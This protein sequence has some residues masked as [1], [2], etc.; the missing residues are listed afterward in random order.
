M[1][2]Y[3]NWFAYVIKLHRN[4]VYFLLSFRSLLLSLPV[5][6]LVHI[7]SYISI[8]EL[9]TSVTRTCK[10]VRNLVETHHILWRHIDFDYHWKLTIIFWVAFLNT[11]SN[12]WHSCFH[13]LFTNVLRRI[14]TTRWYESF[15]FQKV[16]TGCLWLTCHCQHWLSCDWHQIWKF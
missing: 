15:G 9:L 11:L 4:N 5:E 10:A 16:C 7:L 2:S 3:K 12:L 13:V 8:E 14:W 1:L 6:V